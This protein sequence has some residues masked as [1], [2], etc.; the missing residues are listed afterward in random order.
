MAIDTFE[1]GLAR[2]PVATVELGS[3]LNAWRG[4]PDLLEEWGEHDI[5][6]WQSCPREWGVASDED[7]QKVLDK[8]ELSDMRGGRLGG[9][10]RMISPLPSEELRQ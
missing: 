2:L 1:A 3:G 4:E 6:K 9:L 7:M 10:L 8:F 5:R